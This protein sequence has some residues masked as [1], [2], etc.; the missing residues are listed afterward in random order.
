MYR[1]A[2]GHDQEANFVTVTPQPRSPG[3]LATEISHSLNRTRHRQG[4]YTI[5]EYET[6]DDV[7]WNSLID[8]LGISDAS[9]TNEV[10]IRTTDNE[11]AF[12]NMNAVVTMPEIGVDARRERPFWKDVRFYFTDLSST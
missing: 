7:A 10:T 5:W 6:L 3:I 1:I 12:V 2:D 4:L 8:Q 11:R 9:P